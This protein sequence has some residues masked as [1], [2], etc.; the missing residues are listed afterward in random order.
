MDVIVDAEENVYLLERLM[1]RASAPI[2]PGAPRYRETFACLAASACSNPLEPAHLMP[3]PLETVFAK[4][5]FKG[6]GRLSD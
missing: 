4:D 5:K 3:F 2:A 1:M 6:Y